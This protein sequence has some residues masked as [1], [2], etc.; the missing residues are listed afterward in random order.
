MPRHCLLW[1]ETKDIAGAG[2]G[3][4]RWLLHGIAAEGIR[5]ESEE[6]SVRVMTQQQMTPEKF[7]KDYW[8]TKP[9]HIKPSG[10]ISPCRRGR[11]G[12]AVR[13]AAVE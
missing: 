13:V 1:T 7:F 5:A 3:V 4:V 8:E 12:V 10:A 6:R 2:I 9:L 11:S